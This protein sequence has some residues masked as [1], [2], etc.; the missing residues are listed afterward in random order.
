MFPKQHK[1]S[2]D[3]C[4]YVHLSIESHFVGVNRPY[5]LHR[6]EEQICSSF[7]CNSYGPWTPTKCDSV[8]IF[9]SFYNKVCRGI[10]YL[11]QKCHIS[12]VSNVQ[13]VGH[14]EQPAR[15]D[16]KLNKAALWSSANNTNKRLI[17]L[18]FDYRKYSN[19]LLFYKSTCHLLSKWT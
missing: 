1:H 15:T 19:I 7:R 8:V 4:H 3:C 18:K 17:F 9:T 12:Q 13:K 11:T 14:L 10:A 6:K 2:S 16:D 5:E